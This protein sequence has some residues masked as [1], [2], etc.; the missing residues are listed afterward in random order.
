MKKHMVI[1]IGI[2]LC[3]LSA[4]CS[5]THG[6]KTGS[7][8]EITIS[9]VRE[10]EKKSRPAME[11]ELQTGAGTAF[12]ADSV[13]NMIGDAADGMI[14]R[15]GSGDTGISVERTDGGYNITA[16]T[17]DQKKEMIMLIDESI[18]EYIDGVKENGVLPFTINYDIGDGYIEAYCEQKDAESVSALINGI[19]GYIAFGQEACG[20]ISGWGMT[21]TVNDSSTGRTVSRG[22]ISEDDR[23]VISSEDWELEDAVPRESVEPTEPET[24]GLS[25]VVS[26]KPEH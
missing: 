13:I 11:R 25:D 3:V 5:M 21:I 14:E 20:N 6:G 4:G 24:F 9:E 2:F 26:Y 1:P 12:V 15:M 7:G 22:S 8:P 17:S 19:S 18:T 10:P 16:E 23:F